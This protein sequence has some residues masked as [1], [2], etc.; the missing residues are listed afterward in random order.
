MQIRTITGTLAASG[1]YENERGVSLYDYLRFHTTDGSDGYLENAY[2][3]PR[4]DSLLQSGERTYF[5]APLKLPKILGSLQCNVIYAVRERN[6]HIMDVSSLVD[7]SLNPLKAQALLLLIF[8]IFLMIIPPIGI[9]Y[10]IW[11]LRALFCGPPNGKMQDALSAAR[12]ML[13]IP[14]GSAAGAHAS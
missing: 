1:S 12:S 3:L 7:D 2:I 14:Q 11:A 9:L 4:I 10:F 13:P 5:I 6:G 8:S